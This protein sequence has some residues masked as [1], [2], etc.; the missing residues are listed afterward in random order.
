MN[1]VIC[2]DGTGNSFGGDAT[3]V[4][5]LVKALRLNT[6]NEQVAIYHPGVGTKR[7]SLN[8]AYR[9]QAQ[10]NH[11]ALEIS[12]P[13]GLWGLGGPLTRVA[14]L[15]FGAGLQAN[16][17][18]LYAALSRAAYKASNP[19]L[20]F[21]GFSRGAFT[22]RALAGFIHRC[23]LLPPDR[24]QHV[25]GA[26]RSFYNERHREVM[27][28]KTRDDFDRR[29]EDFRRQND[30]RPCPI[31][32]LGLWD[33]VKSYGFI[34]PKSLPHLRHNPSVVAVRHAVALNER[35]S[36]YQFTSWAGVD[37][38]A[39]NDSRPDDPTD[40]KEIWFAGVHADVGG[41]YPPG[42]SGLAREPFEWMVG[43]AR[44]QGLRIDEDA[45]QNVRE[46]FSNELAIHESLHRWWWVAEFLPR[47][48][49][50]NIP[51]A[52]RRIARWGST[53]ERDLR[54]TARNHC[55][56]VHP[57]VH[58]VYSRINLVLKSSDGLRI[59]TVTGGPGTSRSA[60]QS[61]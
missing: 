41:G 36:Y 54:Q 6:P 56:H 15:A 33:T 52:G 49:L 18:S 61:H 30:A 3:N 46:E 21:L 17:E 44:E 27:T 31:H 13:A 25:S 5:R 51:I 4:V 42:E 9:F 47:F 37:H 12:E 1:I 23:G 60:S 53:G 35:R 39:Y 29:L 34:Y 55:V 48:E 19:N 10:A 26:Y 45:L 32:F 11:A 2:A 20:F 58:D 57:S 50:Q 28:Q 14:G 43:E 38:H 59:E 16:V 7:A 22:V 8:A 40:V 24:L